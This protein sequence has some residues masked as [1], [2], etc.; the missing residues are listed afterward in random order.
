MTPTPTSNILL[1][2]GEAATH[3]LG[4]LAL[5]TVTIA[6]L[7]CVVSRRA[8]LGLRV[9]A[10]FLLIVG[11]A[12]FVVAVAQTQEQPSLPERIAGWIP[13]GQWRA[14]DKQLRDSPLETNALPAPGFACLVRSETNVHSAPPSTPQSSTP[15][16]IGLIHQG[17][18]VTITAIYSVPQSN[19][20][21]AHVIALK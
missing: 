18:V 20:I 5:V 1:S 2:L 11:V 7:A 14:D 10:Y 3:P 6:V 17:A 21:W 8:A 19:L 4:S 16:C 15:Q 12:A 13:I 9:S